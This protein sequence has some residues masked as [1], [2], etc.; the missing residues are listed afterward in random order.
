MTEI[1][2]STR[3]TT[4][5]TVK[6]RGGREYETFDYD[7]AQQALT[8]DHLGLFVAECVDCKAVIPVALVDVVRMEVPEGL[9]ERV[10]PNACPAT[11][12]TYMLGHRVERDDYEAYKAGGE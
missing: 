1:Q 7:K 12:S 2:L 11:T 10:I 9:H 6:L 5:Y 8:L 4:L 3:T